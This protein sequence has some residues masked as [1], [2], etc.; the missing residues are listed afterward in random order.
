MLQTAPLAAA[1]R[2]VINSFFRLSLVFCWLNEQHWMLLV[3]V[4]TLVIIYL[5]VALMA[6]VITGLFV[7]QLPE[8]RRG[9]KNTTM[10][11]SS[12]ATSFLA[13]ISQMR[14]TNQLLLIPI[15]TFYGFLMSLFAA[16]FM[17]VRY[18]I[19]HDY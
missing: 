2:R 15:T 18:W 5:I 4:W 13:V 12:I 1:A 10:S 6:V 11:A 9:I 8:D 3:Q 19:K 17:K 16:E 14:T 7:G